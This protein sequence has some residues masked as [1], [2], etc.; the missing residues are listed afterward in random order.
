[1]IIGLFVFGSTIGNDRYLIKLLHVFSLEERV[2]YLKSSFYIVF[3]IRLAHFPLCFFFINL[4]HLS[5]VLYNT[6]FPENFHTY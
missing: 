1:M 5:L 3:L 4:Y 6:T 2:K